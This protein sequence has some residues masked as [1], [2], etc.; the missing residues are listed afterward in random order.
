MLNQPIKNCLENQFVLNDRGDLR[1]VSRT[2]FDI[3]VRTAVLLEDL[4]LIMI[5]SENT[6][7]APVAP[8]I[9]V[10]MRSSFCGGGV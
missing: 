2:F 5:H 1:I 6:N 10:T 7:F 3:F 9:P 8:Q 4:L